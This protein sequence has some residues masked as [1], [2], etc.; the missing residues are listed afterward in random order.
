MNIGFAGTPVFAAT[1]LDALLASK[2]EVLL[3]LTQPGRPAGRG[4]SVRPGPVET[5]GLRHG[6]DVYSPTSLRGIETALEPLDVLVVAAY[7][8]L[9]PDQVLAAPRLGCINVHASLL[10]RWRG[11]SPI[12]HAILHGDEETGV[13]IM[14][15][16]S[17]LDAGPVFQQARLRLTA[18][19]TTTSV[20]EALALLGG[21][22]IEEVLN[23]LE[24]GTLEEPLPQIEADATYAPRLSN[25]AAQINWQENAIQIERHV[26]AFHGRGMAFTKLTRP[27]RTV[28]IRVLKVQK[29]EGAG[30]P[31]EILFTSPVPVIACGRDALA[32]QTVQLSVGKGRP[33]SG[34]DAVNGFADLWQIGSRFENP[35]ALENA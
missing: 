31:G 18:Q 14:Q 15:I 11:A 8:G 17:R 1:I 23:G 9:L 16:T 7:G 24:E 25:E 4:R 13:S 32:L 26:R 22:E 35:E 28:R 33:M 29:A 21:V 27:T 19:S 6:L 34:A 10:P 30:P 12:E 20:T 5:L 2:H 3:I